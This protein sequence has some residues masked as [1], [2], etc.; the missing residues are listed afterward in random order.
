[1][2]HERNLDYLNK[3]RIVYRRAPINDKPS[4]VY[5]WGGYYENGTYECYELFRSKA[6]ITTYKS[7]KWHMLV[8][9]YLNPQL[10]QDAFEHMFKY[11]CY[12]RNGFVTFKVPDQLLSTMVYE[13]SMCD[14]E[15]PP[16]NKQRKIIFNEFCGLTPEE[17]MSI[18]GTLVGRSKKIHE[19]DIYQ[20]MLDLHD[21]G[22]KITINR[23]AGLL[24]CSA[25]TIHRNIG[26]QLKKEKEL[27]NQE[28]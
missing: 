28:L 24:N 19:D 15:K 5:Q 26:N 3:R 11:I 7:L 23:I 25:R 14:L 21:M 12:K 2:S 27:L 10:D 9:W 16:K 17:K 1:M 13:V 4:E 6:K 20:C 22:K 18:V 8:L